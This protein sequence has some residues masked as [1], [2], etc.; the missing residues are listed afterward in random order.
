MPNDYLDQVQVG[1]TTYDLQD[2]AAQ[3]DLSLLKSQITQKANA[4]GGYPEMTAGSAEQLLSAKGLTDK[5]PYLFRRSGGNGANREKEQAVVGG[6]IAWNQLAPAINSTNWSAEANVTA[7]FTDGVATFTSTASSYGV[8]Y[9]S[10][11]GVV[12]Y[13][14]YYVGLTGKAASATTIR[15]IL[16]SSGGS[17]ADIQLG[18]S[19]SRCGV[20]VYATQNAAG[21][22]HFFAAVSASINTEIS[23]KDVIVVDLTA[24]LTPAVADHIY[25]IEYATAGA[26]VAK[27]HEWGLCIKDYYEYDAGSLQSVQVAGKVARGFNQWDE[28]W[29]VGSI[30][31]E[32]GQN[33]PANDRIRSKNY[34]PVLPGVAYY[35]K[36]PLNN[37]DARYYF[38]DA[39]Y[40]F[41]AA[42]TW[43]MGYFVNPANAHYMRFVM[44][45]AYGTAYKND[46]CINL[47]DPTR[48]GEYEPYESH[49]YPLD[50]S[51]TL[52]GIPELD[53]DNNLRYNGDVYK[54]DGTVER[55]Y[56]I[57]DLGTLDWSVPSAAGRTYSTT[58]ITNYKIASVAAER[59]KGIVCSKYPVAYAN[60]QYSDNMDDHSVMRG[61]SSGSHVI[62]RD[63]AA[64]TG[65]TAAE[66][67]AALSGTMLVYE[68]ATQATETADPYQETQ[69]LD[70]YGT[71]EYIDAAVT[72]STPTRDVAIPVGHETDYPENATAKLA[73]LPWDFSTLIANTEK[74][75][76]ATKPYSVNDFLIVNNQLYL[77]TASIA[78]GATITPNTNVT[79]TTLGAQITALLNA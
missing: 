74:G 15:A 46:I 72:A 35:F 23:I 11:V 26:G 78:N 45:T 57:I 44:A 58:N 76:T 75:F 55:R 49:T 43:S 2:S 29:E 34:I 28:E 73:G 77:V 59:N 51:L 48:N 9:V 22:T 13:H 3:A 17:Y 32:N 19:Y 54:P 37:A 10:G 67:K 63:S 42:S 68:F 52:R 62:I 16:G 50:A 56:G 66:V 27:L 33:T 21:V 79:A 47:S 5:V 7:T 18:T 1:S 24:A 39:D 61:D 12:P 60:V 41:I 38:Y 70:P 65:K 6:T 20:L 71:E 40:N 69:L 8:K 14:K 31:A 30:Y 53:A 4:N 64:F 36:D 25:N